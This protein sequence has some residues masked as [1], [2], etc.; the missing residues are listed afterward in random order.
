MSKKFEKNRSVSYLY[1]MCP[2]KYTFIKHPNKDKELVLMDDFGKHYVAAW[3]S[4]VT[5]KVGI[6]FLL[7]KVITKHKFGFIFKDKFYSLKTRSGWV[8]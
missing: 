1:T 5:S 7:K 2:L 4:N 6:T 3:R 8:W